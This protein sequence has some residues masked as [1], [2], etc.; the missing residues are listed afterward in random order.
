M[1]NQINTLLQKLPSNIDPQS[2]LSAIENISRYKA[3]IK[4][5]EAEI[6]RLDVVENVLLTDIEKKYDLYH[7]I[8]HSL[9]SERREAIDKFFEIVDLGIK[10]KNNDL[11]NSGLAG[12][13]QVVSSSPFSNI[14]ELGNMLNNGTQI[15]L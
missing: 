5:S 2:A 12:L 7:K 10:E 3:E 13:S 9:F 14:A 4:K 8:F 1:K 11:I 15:E 6:K